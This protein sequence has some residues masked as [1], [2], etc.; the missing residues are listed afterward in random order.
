[1][2][3][4][5]KQSTSKTKGKARAGSK[6][7]T[8]GSKAKSAKPTK[9]AALPTAGKIPSQAQGTGAS[10]LLERKTTDEVRVARNAALRAWRAA[11]AEAQRAYM[12][13][14]R[15]RR[16]AKTVSNAANSG[17]AAKPPTPTSAAP[18]TDAQSGGDA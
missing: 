3:A 1:M 10:R 2:S 5:E 11:H 9:S 18:T 13:D 6:P 16:K 15:A 7:G 12:A 14:W 8:Q 4:S 17:A